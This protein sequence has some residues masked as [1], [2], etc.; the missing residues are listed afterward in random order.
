MKAKPKGK[1]ISMIILLSSSEL[2][3]AMTDDETKVIKIRA[4]RAM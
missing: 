1:T 3:W 2:S 4:G